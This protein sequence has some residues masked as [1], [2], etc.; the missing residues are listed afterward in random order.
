VARCT[1]R[2]FQIGE[3]WLTQR[4][5]SSAWYRTW[6]EGRVTR[7][8]SLGTDALP[9]AKRKL[10]EWYAAQFQAPT[11]DLPPSAVKLAAVLLDYWNGQACKLRSAETSKIHLRYWNEYWGDV[12]VGDLRNVAKQEAFRAWMF[13][14]G[15]GQNSVNR[16]LEA[17]RAAIRRAWKRGVISAAP[18]IQMLPQAEADPM[19]RPLSVEEWRKLLQH[20]PPP[21]PHAHRHRPCDGR[22]TRSNHRPDT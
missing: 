12:S 9:E 16:C 2:E 7:R 19:G 13:K 11:D 6:L 8:A 3:Y 20:A 21:C 1:K 10:A 17:G 15:L 14:R 22:T 18:Y 4:E 5:G